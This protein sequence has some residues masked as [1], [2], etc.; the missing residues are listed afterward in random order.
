MSSYHD[1]IAPPIATS[2]PKGHS[3][4]RPSSNQKDSSDVIISPPVKRR[5]KT[6]QIFTNLK[7]RNHQVSRSVF[8]K[9]VFI[10]YFEENVCAW[11]NHKILNQVKSENCCGCE[12]RFLDHTCLFDTDAKW[13]DGFYDEVISKLDVGLI[14]VLAK[15]RFYEHFRQ[16]EANS[17]LSMDI[18]LQLNDSWATNLK[19]KMKNFLV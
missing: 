2:T 8:I 15:H 16:D 12:K 4:K 5:V 10:K 17:V 3:G 11:A 9:N 19:T 1:K 6:V 13:I 14:S 18:I 7:K